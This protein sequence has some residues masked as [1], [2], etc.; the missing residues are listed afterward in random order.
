MSLYKNGKIFGK[1]N[2]ID[3][4]V[5]IVVLILIAFL[6]IRYI[7]PSEIKIGEQ[8]SSNK[9]KYTIYVEWVTNT[10]KD[11]IQ[12]GDNIYDKI[13][14]TYIG[15]IVEIEVNPCEIEFATLDGNI[16]MREVPEK[17][18]INLT[19]EVDGTVKNGEYLASNIIRILVG[20]SKQIK[21]KYWMAMGRITKLYV[22]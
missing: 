4:F 18:D 8:I 11:M 17:I 7:E 10:S 9:F 12:E 21:T 19:I 15:K 1:I 20:E 14:G 13:S 6:V 2:I 16:L 22:D 5:I 3:F